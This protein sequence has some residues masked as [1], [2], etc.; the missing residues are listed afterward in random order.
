MAAHAQQC[1]SDMAATYTAALPTVKSD[2]LRLHTRAAVAASRRSA[3]A[4]LVALPPPP[5]LQQGRHA[6]RAKERQTMLSRAAHLLE[7]AGAGESQDGGE[8]GEAGGGESDDEVT[9]VSA[10]VHMPG[11]ALATL[12]H[13]CKRRHPRALRSLCRRLRAQLDAPGHGGDAMQTKLQLGAALHLALFALEADVEDHSHGHGSGSPIVVASASAPATRLSLQLSA[14]PSLGA[15]AWLFRFVE[16][17]FLLMLEKGAPGGARA[18]QTAE[19]TSA[20]E[21]SQS[22]AAEPADHSCQSLSRISLASGW[23]PQV[24][25]LVSTR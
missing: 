15:H 19:G 12:L 22:A 9:A 8:E 4:A 14:L 2:D 11:D 13:Q 7:V 25:A 23:Q 3:P 21:L 10:P 24:E 17:Y 18:G 6:D 1:F 20:S 5:P 16:A